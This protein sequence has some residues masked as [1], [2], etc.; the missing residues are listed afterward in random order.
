MSVV[1]TITET[2]PSLSLR[3]GAEKKSANNG[4]DQQANS[5]YKYARLLPVFPKD[6]H[7]DPLVP[8]EHVDPAF[9]ALS[10]PNPRSFLDNAQV[11]LLT[12]RLGS[13]VRGISL[14]QLDNAGRDQLALEV[15]T[16]VHLI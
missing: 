16:R 10:H 1:E 15:S 14:A 9:R 4:T 3:Q 5:D 6:E 13:E 2:L 7:Y 12:P 8:F 11:S